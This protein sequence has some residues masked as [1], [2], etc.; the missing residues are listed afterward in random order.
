MT[1]E[2][3]ATVLWLRFTD[4]SIWGCRCT[5]AALGS[6]PVKRN[7]RGLEETAQHRLGRNVR[8]LRMSL[9]PSASGSTQTRSGCGT[10]DNVETRLWGE[11]PETVL[12]SVTLSS[13]RAFRGRME[14]VMGGYLPLR[15][16]YGNR[17]Q[18]CVH[19]ATP[20]ALP[21]STHAHSH[22]WLCH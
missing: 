11:Q 22:W 2:Y 6:H 5:A 7:R 21:V 16:S 18:S 3:F 15:S 12:T 17:A 8:L 1:S 4:S 20:T 9:G 13:S 14:W 19:S 10:K